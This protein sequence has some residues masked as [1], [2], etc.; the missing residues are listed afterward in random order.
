MDV[1]DNFLFEKMD[2]S[3]EVASAFESTATST[4]EQSEHEEETTTFKIHIDL[5]KPAWYYRAK[6][7]IEAEYGDVITLFGDSLVLLNHKVED[8][9][10]CGTIDLLR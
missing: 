5:S 10:L 6:T 7:T 2:V 3:A 9:G 4:F 1:S 8:S